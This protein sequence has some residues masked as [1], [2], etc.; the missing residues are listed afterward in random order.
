MRQAHDPDPILSLDLTVGLGTAQR[1][2]GDPAY[3][4]TLLSAARRA[5]E[6][7]DTDRLVGA[8]LA[9]DRG[10]FS[11][12]G[13]VNP[14]NIEILETALARLPMDHPDRA[15]VLAMLCQDLTYSSP[16]DRRIA[17]A[18]EAL[19][20]AESSGHDAVI[21]RVLNLIYLR[22]ARAVKNW[23]NR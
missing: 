4:G 12:F 7:G 14:D 2:T 18:E 21:V 15:L 20:I 10:F 22:S 8:V 19:A 1:Q 23:N 6:Q 16:L 9:S 17:L 3:R 5:A 11:T 13:T